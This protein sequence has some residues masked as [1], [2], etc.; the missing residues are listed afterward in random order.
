MKD[1]RASH[2]GRNYV[3]PFSMENSR[4]QMNTSLWS[5]LS[6][7]RGRSGLDLQHHALQ[8][9]QAHFQSQPHFPEFPRE[10]GQPVLL[11]ASPDITSSG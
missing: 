11:M 9:G 2:I 6:M 8:E 4:W 7:A 10:G 3:K 5:C 1:R